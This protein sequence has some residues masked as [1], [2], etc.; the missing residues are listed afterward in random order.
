MI[1]NPPA[2]AGA[3]RDTGS[4]PGPGRSPGGA[5]RGGSPLLYS[6]LENSMDRGAWHATVHRITRNQT[7]VAHPHTG[8]LEKVCI[9]A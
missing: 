4:V 9:E 6:C 2:N 8:R 5:H 3:T 7:H 1:K